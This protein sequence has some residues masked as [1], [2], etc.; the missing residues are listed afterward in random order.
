MPLLGLLT[1]VSRN[2]CGDSKATHIKVTNHE[3]KYTYHVHSIHMKNH[4]TKRNN[5]KQ[6][7][8]VNV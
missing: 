6:H 3:Y 5:M 8:I 4:L 2:E 7:M 1:K